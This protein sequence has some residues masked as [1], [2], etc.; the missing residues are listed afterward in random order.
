VNRLRVAAGILFDAGGRV[1]I[2]ERVGGGPFQGMWEFPGGKIGAGESAVQ[3]LARELEEEL[4]IEVV[5]AEHFMHLDHDYPDRSVA[6]DFFLVTEWKGEPA[7]RDGQTLNWVQAES[8][9]D[10][11]LLPADVPVI[12]ALQHMAS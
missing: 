6:I 7:G 1:L 4:G 3:A 9:A 2:A 12:E 10:Q 5:A 11:G 8:L